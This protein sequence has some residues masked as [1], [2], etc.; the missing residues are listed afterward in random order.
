MD[1][2][3]RRHEIGR[4]ERENVSWQVNM[5]S[6]HLQNRG[7]SAVRSPADRFTLPN[8]DRDNA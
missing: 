5:I 8:P 2:E 4:P 3:H 7:S 1:G 6:T